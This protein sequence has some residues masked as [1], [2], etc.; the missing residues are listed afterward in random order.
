[1]VFLMTSHTSNG[2]YESLV[3][4][5]EKPIVMTR[6]EPI[7]KLGQSPLPPEQSLVAAILEDRADRDVPSAPNPGEQ[8][9]VRAELP[10]TSRRIPPLSMEAEAAIVAALIKEGILL[11]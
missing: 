9:C 10:S 8:G 7:S 1:M 11:R 2:L 5:A 6:Y 3:P 4:D